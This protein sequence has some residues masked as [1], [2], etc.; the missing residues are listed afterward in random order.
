[1]KTICFNI[2]LIFLLLF[3]RPLLAGDITCMQ[4]DGAI[5]CKQE[6]NDYL[7]AGSRY[8]EKALNSVCDEGIIKRKIPKKNWWQRLTFFSIRGDN[9]KTCKINKACYNLR[10]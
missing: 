4:E 5:S 1:M 7:C 8:T 3:C 10:K 9:K 2:L 6:G